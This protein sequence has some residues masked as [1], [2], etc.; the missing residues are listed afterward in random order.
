V[1]TQFPADA[2]G[3]LK[4][5]HR[6]YLQDGK[7]I[8]NAKVAVEGLPDVS[9]TTDDFCEDTGSRRF[10]DLGAHKGMGDAMS[11]GMV[12]CFSIW[13]DEGGFMSWLDGEKDGAGPCKEG[14]GAPTHVREVEGDP[15]VVFSSIK[16]GEIGSTFK[17]ECQS[18]KLKH[19]KH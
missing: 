8:Q 13:W 3:N 16:W 5:I 12:L 10:M 6:L 7:I 2:D 17:P 11:R 14:E 15:T 1:V 18:T 19:R 9:Y 4:E